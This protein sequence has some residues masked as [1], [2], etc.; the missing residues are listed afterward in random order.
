[1]RLTNGGVEMNRPIL[2]AYDPN[3]KDPGP[4]R[5]ALAAGRFS[6]APVIVLS[7]CSTSVIAAYP[8]PAEADLLP[9]AEPALE[10]LKVELSPGDVAVEY[11]TVLGSSAPSAL[12]Q[13]AEREGALLLVVGST[14]RGTAGRLFPGSTADRL[15]HGAPCPIAVIPPGWSDAGPPSTIGVAY[16]E[17]E[18][19]HNALRTAHGLARRSGA[20]LR[21]I[22]VADAGASAHLDTE[23]YR[24]G[25]HGTSVED[26]Q[27]EHRVRAEAAV[28]DAVAGFDGDVPVEVDAFLED[29]AEVLLRISEHLDLLICGSRGYGPLRAVLLGGVTRRVTSEARCPVIVVPRGL[30]M[31]EGSDGRLEPAV[32]A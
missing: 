20:T 15:M 21:V 27:G 11:R 3:S 22:T 7:V 32:S 19:G 18:E 25:Q 29:P 30:E 12:H 1:M 31:R 23:A 9:N 2:A 17:T 10:A 5:F 26:V 16:V 28:R 13:A 24:P 14:A 6:G 4:A 8:K